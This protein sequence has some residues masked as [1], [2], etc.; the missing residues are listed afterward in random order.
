MTKAELSR[1]LDLYKYTTRL[2]LITAQAFRMLAP[3]LSI[4]LVASS[5]LRE[6]FKAL[7]TRRPAAWLVLTLY[8][9]TAGMFKLPI[10]SP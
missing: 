5:R 1:A 6:G 7:L 4:K 3:N 2:S 8:S 10:V 9:S